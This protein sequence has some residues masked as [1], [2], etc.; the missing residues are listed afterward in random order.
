[1]GATRRGGCD[2]DSAGSTGPFPPG[3]VSLW[4]IGPDELDCLQLVRARRSAACS[5]SVATSYLQDD[6]PRNTFRIGYGAIHL[7]SIEPGIVLLGRGLRRGVVE[8]TAVS[9]RAED[10]ALGESLLTHRA[11][12]PRCRSPR[13]RSQTSTEGTPNQNSAGRSNGSKGVARIRR[14]A[15]RCRWRVTAG[16]PDDLKSPTG[17]PSGVNLVGTKWPGPEVW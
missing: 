12:R 11:G 1:M 15:T 10:T 5:S 8:C 3:G 17:S 6:P 2:N 4:V 14:S 7:R 13:S 16:F 9:C